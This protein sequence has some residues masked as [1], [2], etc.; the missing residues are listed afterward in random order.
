MTTINWFLSLVGGK[1]SRAAESSADVKKRFI[2]EFRESHYVRHNQ[3]RQEHLASLGLP[4]AGRSVLEL[5]AGIGDHTTFF[6]DRNCSVCTS[7]GRAELYEILRER[8]HWM[9]TEHIDLEDEN[10]TFADVYDIVYAYGLLYHLGNPAEALRRM[11]GWCGDV[12][13]LETAVSPQDDVGDNLVSERR[14]LGSQA[15]SGTGS[16]PSRR[17]VFDRLRELFPHVYVTTTQPW[18]PEFPL[19]WANTP[20]D[21]GYT[22]CVFVASRTGLALPTPI[23]HLPEKQERH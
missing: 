10:L 22:R 3:R 17:W 21:T 5:G 9:R 6:I 19:D 2:A 16:R 4:I 8:Y 15:V 20:K 7:D 18:H 11:A 1:G 12:L 23:S 14:E 13:L